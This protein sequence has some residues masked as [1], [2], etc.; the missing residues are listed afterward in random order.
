MSAINILTIGDPHFKVKNIQ[1]IDELITEL[2]KVSEDISP[3]LIVILGDVLDQHEKIHVEPLSKVTEMFSKLEKIA[4]IYSLVGNHDRRN[5][6]DFLT[7]MHPFTAI[8]HWNDNITIVDKVIKSNIKGH[9]FV[10]VPYV[11]PGR[12]MEALNTIEDPLDNVTAIFAHQEFFKAKMG[13][14]TSNVGDKWDLTNPLVIS[15]HIHDYDIL[16]KNIIYVGTPIQ[17]AFGDR[18]DKTISLF[19]W[20]SKYDF[21]EQRI[22]LNLK[23]KFLYNI[24]YDDFLKWKIPNKKGIFKLVISGTTTEIQTIIKLPKTSQLERDKVIIKYKTINNYNPDKNI[25]KMDKISFLESLYSEITINTLEMTWFKKLFG[26]KE[27]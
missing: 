12:F 22:S 10:F 17:H 14:V 11:S 18:D 13:A 26:D 21:K 9:N 7:E 4:P 19:K 20:K 25:P 16:Q 23:R 24:N 3:D 15:G 8:K 2:I 6:S 27:N 5:N 1:E